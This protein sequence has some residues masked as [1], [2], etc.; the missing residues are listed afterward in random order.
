MEPD[1][2]LLTITATTLPVAVAVAL[3]LRRTTQE[4]RAYT[5]AAA[6]ILTAGSTAYLIGWLG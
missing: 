6:V 1:A 4:I 2:I 3:L 5:T